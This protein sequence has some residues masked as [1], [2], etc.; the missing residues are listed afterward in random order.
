MKTTGIGWKESMRKNKYI[1]SVIE[2]IESNLSADIHIEMVASRQAL[3][4]SQLYRDFYAYTGHSVKA[5]I[6]KRRISNACER[7][8]CSML[9]LA[10]ITDESGY[11]TQQAFQK[12]FKCIVGMTPLEYRQS[13]AY[14]YF[15]PFSADE[16]S[17]AV[18]VGNEDIPECTTTKFYNTC[19]VG[20][21]D[22]AIASLGDASRRVFGRN[23]KQIGKQFCY[24]VMNETGVV[25]SDCAGK[26]GTY[27]TCVVDY[28][29]RD[30]NDGWNYLYNIWL[31]ASM[32][33]QSGDGYFEEYL[34]KN[35]K[36]YKLKL[37]L[38]V[39]KRKT[40]RH[41]TISQIP[42]MVFIIAREKGINAERKASEKVLGILQE[43]HPI[44]IRSAQRFYV[45]AYD[46]V[47]ECGVECGSEE[48]VP[49]DGGC[50]IFRVPAGRY[51]VMPDDCFGDIRV[52]EEK[53]TAWLSNNSVIQ[54]NGQPV[55]A[56]YEILNGR[57][58]ADHIRMKLYKLIQK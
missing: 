3:S 31:S 55:F 16:I 24:E 5:Y 18:K 45:C 21:E 32:F 1:N 30:I 57:Y 47:Y 48:T 2:F 29:E 34:F 53:M 56:V 11:Q 9:P 8:K 49:S 22:K 15:Y 6:R 44:L 50:E 38:P 35:G 40:T 52:G 26:A 33:E 41:I 43:C 17:V 27:A 7:L 23:G 13:D 25:G 20:I 10:V 39:K 51:A 54:E 42:E 12:Q 19:M 36:P 37:Y 28:N 46:G 4:L 58:D 14:Y